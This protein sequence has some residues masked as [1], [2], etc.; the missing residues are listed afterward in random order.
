ME[1]DSNLRVGMR[2]FLNKLQIHQNRLYGSLS[3]D[4]YFV[5]KADLC[6]HIRKQ[7]KAPLWY[8]HVSK[9]N[10]FFWKEYIFITKFHF[11][12]TKVLKITTF[13]YK[14]YRNFAFWSRK[15]GV[16]SVT[17]TLSRRES[18]P[19][20]KRERDGTTSSFHFASCPS[21]YPSLVK[22]ALH[23]LN[24]REGWD[25]S[26]NYGSLAALRVTAFRP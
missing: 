14:F 16:F 4:V 22:T 3:H 17:S 5:L 7:I 8:V 20:S 18:P 6:L 11:L 19:L 10:I 2:D 12:T 23:Y 9:Y 1:G 24:T 15:E 26:V 13:S 21:G 25:D